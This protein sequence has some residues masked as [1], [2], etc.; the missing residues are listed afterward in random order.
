MSLERG[1]RGLQTRNVGSVLNG[2]SAER[3]NPAIDG[4]DLALKSSDVSGLSIALVLDIAQGVL[5][6]QD[7]S[8]RIVNII[9]E[10][11]VIVIVRVRWHISASTPWV[12]SELL[13]I[14][15]T[16]DTNEASEGEV[17]HFN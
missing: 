14:S 8:L 4:G 10:I 7:L 5:Q 2:L 1:E 16:C 9:F 11:I 15:S 6:S 13:D 17:H 12:L 3:L